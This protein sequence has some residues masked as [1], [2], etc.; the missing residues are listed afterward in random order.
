MLA[1]AASCRRTCTIHTYVSLARD[2]GTPE[3]PTA[4]GSGRI[5]RGRQCGGVMWIVASW[6]IT[7]THQM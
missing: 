2:G 7:Q 4:A 3:S 5:R 1:A 6:Y